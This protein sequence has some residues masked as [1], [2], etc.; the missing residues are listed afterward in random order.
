MMPTQP[1]E[2]V[3]AARKRGARPQCGRVHARGRIPPSASRADWRGGSLATSWASRSWWSPR[4]CGRRAPCSNGSCC[5][6]IPASGNRCNGSTSWRPAMTR[7]ARRRRCAWSRSGRRPTRASRLPPARSRF[8][9]A[10]HRSGARPASALAARRPLDAA[11]S[12]RAQPGQSLIASVLRPRHGRGSGGRRDPRP[13]A[14]RRR[15]R[16]GPRA[17]S[18]PRSWLPAAAAP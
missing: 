10:R 18:A 11:R 13:R 14:P 7:S 2:I 3:G 17:R 16:S 15:D 1:S 4:P 8:R 9:A 12:A 6:S 5:S